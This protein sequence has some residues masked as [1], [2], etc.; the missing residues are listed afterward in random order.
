MV[1]RSLLGCR[2]SREIRGNNL[3]YLTTVA[4][5]SQVRFCGLRRQSE[6]TLA[7]VS[8]SSGA[9]RA[10]AAEEDEEDARPED[11]EENRY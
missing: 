7:D 8:C 2:E 9:T 1:G 10:A 4:F 3:T 6:A 5:I 11:E